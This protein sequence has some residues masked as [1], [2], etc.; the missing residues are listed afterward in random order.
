MKGSDGALAQARARE[1][2]VEPQ[3]ANRCAVVLD[4]LQGM[5]D[6][7]HRGHWSGVRFVTGNGDQG[8]ALLAKYRFEYRCVAGSRRQ[9]NGADTTDL[10]ARLL[11]DADIDLL[12]FVGGDGT[13]RDVLD[14]MGQS[15]SQV[16]VFG[17]P[18]G[19]KMHSG[20]FATSPQR[21]AELIALLVQG[22]LVSGHPSMVRDI[23]E[24]ALRGGEIRARDYGELLVPEPA[25]YLQH[26]KS[27]GKEVEE[28]VLLD[29]A[30]EVQ[31]MFADFTG[32]LAIGP[33]SS[34]M[35]IKQAFGMTNPTLLGFDLLR[36]TASD[37]EARHCSATPDVTAE[38]LA[39]ALPGLKVVLSFSRV[40]GFLIGRGNQQL[41]SLVLQT[42]GPEGLCI[43]GSRTKLASLEG[44]PLLV[45]SGSAAL[46]RRFSGLREIISGFDD[47]LLYRVQHG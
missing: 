15:D 46:D 7:Q 21:A 44:R 6:V 14:A 43:V 25:G 13:A 10:V 16:P 20:V 45:D 3:S 41:S 42:L 29:I 11:A 34:C 18:A 9:Y 32:A 33:G 39:G 38:T 37:F 31:A 36:L 22:G 1:L 26:L 23:D 47:R 27:G 40:Q 28:L 19:V 17:I 8:G 30:A 12:V 24:R 4:H 5:Q 35:A 2:N